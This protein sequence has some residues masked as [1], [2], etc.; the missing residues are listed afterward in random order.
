MYLEHFNFE[1][2]PFALTPNTQYFCNLPM[3]QEALNVLLVSLRSGEGFVKIIGEA[4]TGKTLLCRHFINNLGENF[5][6]AYVPNPRLSPFELY[7]HLIKELNIASSEQLDQYLATELLT[8]TLLDLHEKGRS[9]VVV[10][11]EAQA[12]SDESLEALRL[13]SNLE[14]EESK[15]L[16]IVLFGQ[17]E[18]DER[19]AQNHLRQLNQRIAFSYHLRPLTQKEL[20]V[21]LSH[22]L[23]M[24]GYTKEGLFSPK[25]IQFLYQS[26][27]GIPRLVNI[28]AHKSL[29][30]AYGQNQKKVNKKSVYRA[31]LDTESVMKP[32]K[33]LYFISV[34]AIIL[35]GILITELYLI[36]FT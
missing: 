4:G 32:S 36:Y 28:L 34:F 25:A 2:Q 16:Q 19:L 14:T 13:L 10:V 31:F 29:M 11:D 18:L 17:P 30:I 8:Q 23:A 24:T 5:I 26:S 1:E 33:G 6:T 3:Y 27:G 15:L 22:R 35:L 20:L 12:M 9:V 21:Y 7:Q